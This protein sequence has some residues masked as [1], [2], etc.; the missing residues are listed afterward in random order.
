MKYF[1]NKTILP[2]V[3]IAKKINFQRLKPFQKYLVLLCCYIFC[4]KNTLTYLY[5]TKLT[6]LQAIYFFVPDKFKVAG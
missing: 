3:Q 1:Y 2:V 6:A 5:K 4:N